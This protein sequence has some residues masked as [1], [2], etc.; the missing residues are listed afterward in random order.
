MKTQL[1]IRFLQEVAS[2]YERIERALASFDIACAR[3]W[4]HV[5]RSMTGYGAPLEGRL[6]IPLH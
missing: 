3:G 2:R 4:D 5:E 6:S 1:M